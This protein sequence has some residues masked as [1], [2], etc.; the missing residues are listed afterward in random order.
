MKLS[1]MNSITRGVHIEDDREETAT[2]CRVH[3]CI[4]PRRSDDGP[5]SLGSR[6]STARHHSALIVGMLLILS[7][8]FAYDGDFRFFGSMILC[9][10]AFTTTKPLTFHA[11]LSTSSQANKNHPFLRHATIAPVDEEHLVDGDDEK[12]AYRATLQKKTVKDLRAMVKHMTPPP[13]RGI[14]SKLKLKQDFVRFLAEHTTSP[15]G[16]NKIN[17]SNHNNISS[18]SSI[19]EETSAVTSTASASHVKTKARTR[20]ARATTMPSLDTVVDDDDDTGADA[21]RKTKKELILEEVAARYPGLNSTSSHR[22]SY[23]YDIEQDVRAR[24]HPMLVNAPDSSEMDLS[25]VGTASCTPGITRGVSCTALRLNWRRSGGGAGLTSLLQTAAAGARPRHE[26]GDQTP[27]QS[28]DGGDGKKKSRQP[29]QR[30]NDFVGGTWIFDCGECTQ[31]QLQKSPTV[32]P[33]K[34][35]K[36]FITHCHGDHSFGLPGLLCLMGQD[37]PR[38]PDERGNL[39]PP[40][41]I[42]GPEGLRSWLRVAIR[43]SI[44]RIVPPYRVHELMNVP[45]APEW[46]MIR[47]YKDGRCRFFYDW[48][49]VGGK[50]DKSWMTEWGA[51]GIAG[52]DPHSW[53][54]KCMNEDLIERDS[55]YGEIEGGRDIYPDYNSPMCS[56]GAPIW[57]VEDEGDVVVHA[58]PMSHGVPCVGYVVKETSRPGRIFPDLVIP[59][60]ERNFSALKKAGVKMP[61][62]IMAVIKNL[63][64]DGAFTFPDGTVIKHSDVVEPP[65]EGRKV[66]IC[67]DTADTRAIENLAQDANVVV[68]EAT[69]AFLRGIDIGSNKY[70][71]TRDAR[72]HGHSTP[73]LAGDFAKRVNAK[74]LIINHFSSRYK[75]DESLESVAIMT[76][77]EKQAIVASG[78]SE[79]SV[80]AAWDFMLCPIAQN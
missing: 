17:N 32:K 31:L 51:Q 50:G 64:S 29:Q 5:G 55:Y 77:I 15:D 37:R 58:A 80:C 9:S 25:F 43:Y 69:N 4:P 12:E 72:I 44:S 3:G 35:T 27:P 10:H 52:D 39:P 1:N 54:T 76:R 48:N 18:S 21:P 13:P 45:M 75:G 7:S 6:R 36:I 70:S 33:G 62:K 16:N 56:A 49:R 65:R 57:E 47:D 53:I 60:I 67:G 71:V 8:P 34:I 26:D 11:I 30:S 28:P 63:P 22:V 23:D 73:D 14:T 59:V 79:S 61:M 24:Y 20:K 2:R 38:E 78:L 68:H 46:K 42:Y 40:I 41:D 19:N 66:V 74:N